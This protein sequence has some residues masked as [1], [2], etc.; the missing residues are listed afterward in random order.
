MQRI[1][2]QEDD[3]KGRAPERLNLGH[4]DCRTNFRDA[5]SLR[6]NAV[7]LSTDVSYELE[8]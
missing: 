3:C 6:L 4:V 1:N 8:G 5:I 2:A 7:G